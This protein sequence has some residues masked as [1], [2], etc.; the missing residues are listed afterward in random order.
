MLKIKIK[1]LKSYLKPY[2]KVNLIS[3][4]FV[5]DFELSFYFFKTLTW[6]LKNIK[7]YNQNSYLLV[8][9]NLSLDNRVLKKN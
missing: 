8:Y 7:C 2:K 1:L 4:S 9:G 5:F 6:K 3:V